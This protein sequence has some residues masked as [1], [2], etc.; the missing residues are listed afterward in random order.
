MEKFRLPK[1][2][3]ALAL[4]AG[5]TVTNASAFTDTEGH[6]AQDAISK[7]SENYGLIT[8]YEDGTFRP[9]ASIT[10]GAFA[11]ILDR[12]LKFRTASASGTFSDTAGAYWESAIL[13]LHAAG[14]YL[15]NGGKALSGASIT[16]QQAV[17]MIARA[18]DIAVSSTDLPY[19]DAS[20][21]SSY[22]QGPVAEMTARGYLTDCQN[23]RFRPTDPIT[24]AEIVNILNNMIQVL[25]QDTEVYSGNVPG[26]VM[27]NYSGGA[28]LMDMHV[29]GDLILAPGVEDTVTL[30]NVQVDGEIRNFSA[31]TPTVVESE[32]PEEDEP[33]TPPE[34][35]TPAVPGIQPSEIYTPSKTTGEYISYGGRSI[36][37]YADAEPI[38]LYNGDFYWEEDRLV[39]TG[40]AFDTRFGIDVSAYQNRAS[41]NETIDWQAVADDGVE[42]AMVRVGL[43]GYSNGALFSDAFYKQNIQGAMEAGIETGVYFFAQAITVEEA[44]EEADFVLSLLKDQKIDGPVA[45]DWE[46]HD[47]SYRVYGTTPEM[48]TACAIAFCRR[49]EEA[50]Y[51]AMV[52]AGQYVSYMKYDQGALAPY[53]S[54]YPEYK[55]ASSEKLCPTYYYQMDYWQFSSSC[56]VDGIGGRVDANLQFLR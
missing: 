32:E 30:V 37:V 27:V 11:G 45:Y 52:Y 18:F 3:A 10:R 7:W 2:L 26:T 38:Q 54:W 36:P 28:Y 49:I 53:L 46:M 24:R 48:A 4:A 23:G 12:F 44:I 14:V 29:A 41:A 1:Q 35:E 56:T 39:Y 50:G 19:E 15:G 42:F 16:R 55:S 47:S 13:K 34:E 51:D 43:R 22:A 31:V 6:W 33:V 5:L 40:G 21:I 25:I 20:E 17:T 8:G 9:D